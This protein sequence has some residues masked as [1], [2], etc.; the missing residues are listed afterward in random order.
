[1]NE[2]RWILCALC[3]LFKLPSIWASTRIKG[4]RMTVFKSIEF[5]IESMS[6]LFTLTESMLSPNML[7]WESKQIRLK[8]VRM[9]KII[10]ERMTNTFKNPAK[11]S[12]KRIIPL[13]WRYSG[14]VPVIC[15]IN[16]IALLVLAS[17]A[18]KL[19]EKM[20]V[21][22]VSYCDKYTIFNGGAE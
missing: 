16:S 21:E 17:N 12:L 11:L 13:V 4:K 3:I 15:I 8:W 6:N 9:I 18:V 10:R 22:I 7:S 5:I 20:L 19:Q 14:R 1:M 2:Q